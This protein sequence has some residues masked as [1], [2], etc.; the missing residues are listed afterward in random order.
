MIGMHACFFALGG[1]H[2]GA[3]APGGYRRYRVP[4]KWAVCL[5]N[6]LPPLLAGVHACPALPAVPCPMHML[7]LACM[8]GHPACLLP[9]VCLAAPSAAGFRTPCRCTAGAA[10]ATHSA[11]CPNDNILPLAPCRI[12]HT[13]PLHHVHGIVNA[14]L[15]PLRAGTCS[16]I[17]PRVW[18]CHG[19]LPGCL[20]GCL[21]ASHAAALV[22]PTPALAAPSKMRSMEP[23]TAAL[24]SGSL[25]CRRLR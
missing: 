2:T 8:A 9:L 7:H 15:C 17:S 14:L 21:P 20:P 25:L 12:L 10:P 23:A 6:G 3:T 16:R 1:G 5:V 11:L 22:C 24:P 13:L 4:T 19:Q 18:C